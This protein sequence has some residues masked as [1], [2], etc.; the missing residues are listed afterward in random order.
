VPSAGLKIEV[1][2]IGMMIGGEALEGKKISLGRSMPP[3]LL[4]RLAGR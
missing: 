2:I 1:S 4:K 3:C